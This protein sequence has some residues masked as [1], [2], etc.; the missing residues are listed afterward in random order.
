M[1]VQYGNIAC[2]VVMY[3]RGQIT[4]L[5]LWRPHLHHPVGL[6]RSGVQ[7]S[8]QQFLNT[9]SGWCSLTLS[10]QPKL[11]HGDLLRTLSIKELLERGCNTLA[12]E[13]WFQGVPAYVES[14]AG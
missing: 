14:A 6:N 8:L 4:C 1:L 7:T 11:L 13:Q 10:R 9:R 12:G 5:L 3:S 2:P